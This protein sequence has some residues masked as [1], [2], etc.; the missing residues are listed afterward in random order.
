MNWPGRAA[1]T[2]YLWLLSRVERRV[3][4][5]P[6]ERIVRLQQRRLQA[7]VR[8]AYATVPFYRQVMDERG[9]RPA[10]LQ[11]VEDLA[12][13][14]LI[15]DADLR[16]RPEQFVSSRYDLQSCF[17]MHT[18]GTQ[19]GLPTSIYCDRASTLRMLA[20]HERHRT[21]LN[22]LVGQGWGQV[23]LYILIPTS[24]T[25]DVRAF[26]DAQ[27]LTPRGLAHRQYV[28][29]SL[30]LDR[31]IDKMNEIRPV[32]VFSL[33]SYAD[34]FARYVA[35]RS[36]DVALPRVWMYGGD[37]LSLK[38]REL[39]EVHLGC[40]VYSTYQASETGR[41]GFQCERCQGFHLNIDLCAVRL[42]DEEG[43][44]VP[45]GERGEV[46]I[47]NL[48]NR[49]MVLLNLR[50]GDLAV[51]SPEPCPCGRSLPVLER[52]EG[53]RSEAIYLPDTRSLSVYQVENACAAP[54]RATLASQLV[55]P[56][57]DRLTWRVVPLPGADQTALRQ[58]LIVTTTT[59]LDNQ[60]QVEVEFV[61]EIARTPGGKLR[62]LERPTA[63]RSTPA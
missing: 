34:Q 20:C 17:E 44:T 2:L 50:L 58:Q 7:T 13:L 41:L 47:S 46:V 24:T 25:L 15:D 16:Y 37:M 39:L 59:F 57:A 9:L 55:Q 35:D 23:Q 42:V 1:N 10:D 54:L 63:G 36:L 29:S 48:H 33:G 60:V 3:P 11:S 4:F 22:R 18:S 61:P 62:R 30:P 38:G 6:P 27:T 5:W 31:V 32:V 8:H 43:R 56:T 26:W 28:S 12:R 45:P 21:V 40:R 53:K 19:T 14:P 49:A 52:L 51:L